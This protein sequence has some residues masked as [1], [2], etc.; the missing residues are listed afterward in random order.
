MGSA[1]SKLLAAASLPLLLS[2]AQAAT[3]DLGNGFCSHGVGTTAGYHRGAVATVDGKGRDVVLMWL[4]DH[5]GGYGFLMVDAE[6]GNSEQL[7]MPFP[8]VGYAAF[9]SILSSG[10]KFYTHFDGHFTEFDPVERAFT[11]TRKCGG[12][13]G[14]G[15]TEDDNGVIWAFTIGVPKRPKRALVSF[16]PKTRELK[17]FTAPEGGTWP[18]W[19]SLL[20]ADDAG[21]IY[22]GIG[23]RATHTIAFD[24][25]TSME[26]PIL[27]DE[28]PRPGTAYLYRDLD[29]EV[30]GTP[31]YDADATW[32]EFY[33]GEARKVGK[34][35]RIQR[36]P[37]IT[38]NQG[39]F[40]RDFPDGK[41]I[42]TLD[43]AENLLA[44]EDP[45][46]G[47][48]KEVRFT[49]TTESPYIMGVAAAPD[50]TICGGTAFPMRFV[51]FNPKADQWISRPCYSQ[52]N[53]VASQGG[54][55]F[56][57]GYNRGSL[58]EWDPSRPW[59][60]TEREKQGCNP[61]H[62]A[63]S[64]PA[65]HRPHHLLAYPDG[66]TL[67]LSGLPGGLMF[68]D[69]ETRTRTLVMSSD[70]VPHHSTTS[71]MALPGGKL[72][73]GTARSTTGEGTPDS[74]LYIM[75]VATKRVEWREALL[76]DVPAYKDL[77]A[78]PGGLVYGV[79]H[80]AR[81][82]VFDPARRKVVREEDLGPTLGPVVVHQGP[83]VFVFGPHGEIYMLFVKG[84]AR[85]EPETYRVSLLAESPVPISAGGDILD[86]RLYFTNGPS[87]YSWRLP[88]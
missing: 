39:L 42:K 68:W 18:T 13:L 66:K 35:E 85:V 26:K 27:L 51:S 33:K 58:L 14:S 17:E 16:D 40:H 53:T 57:G 21:W 44:V 77:C 19:V 86:G 28:D 61:L 12:V 3:E 48:V 78:A 38:A 84:I 79:A 74:E 37:I 9:S 32:Y 4:S 45:K 73:G 62:L 54:R 81:F 36:K 2:A 25:R 87:L 76:A 30:Y 41:R 83:R 22:F 46:T 15:M 59:V 69:R 52:W 31:V 7:P 71:L 47:Q 10:N 24:P 65:I 1:C 63:D 56:I 60:A 67:V 50:G 34:R 64:R 70:I 88:E 80:P 49:Y 6:T 5:R 72:L 75:D 82:F 8:C 29:G 20:A 43:M 11:F 55:L 23:S